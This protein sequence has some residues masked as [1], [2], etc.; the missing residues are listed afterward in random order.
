MNLC[1]VTEE[2]TLLGLDSHICELQLVPAPLA[3]L[4]VSHPPTQSRTS[5]ARR[6][7]SWARAHP[8]QRTQMRPLPRSWRVSRPAAARRSPGGRPVYPRLTA[9]QLSAARWRRC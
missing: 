5:S 7:R 9:A 2:S 4:L 8:E 1:L 3:P 6:P